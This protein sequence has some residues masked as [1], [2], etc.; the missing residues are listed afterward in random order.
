[1]KKDKNKLDGSLIIIIGLIIIIILLV[2]VIFEV[3][4]KDDKDSYN[5][6]NNGVNSTINADD[7]KISANAALEIA[8]K[9][10][11]I[12]SSKVYDIDIELENKYGSIVYEV[13]FYSGIHEYAYF[14]D[15]VSGKILHTFKEIDY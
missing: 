12:N 15:A 6:S 11:N 2:I 3:S 9:D 14:I 8:L 10:L 7:I 1:M 4:D 5:F 13:T